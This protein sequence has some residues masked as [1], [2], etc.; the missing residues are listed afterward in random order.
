MSIWEAVDAA[1][2]RGYARLAALLLMF[3]CDL[4]S[5]LTELR[6]SCMSGRWCVP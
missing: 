4:L 2:T 5:R 1:R 3:E 6:G